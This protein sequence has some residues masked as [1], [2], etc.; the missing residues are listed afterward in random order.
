[1]RLK[2]TA[3]LAFAALAAGAVAAQA[4]PVTVALFRFQAQG[5]VNAFH[6]VLGA[7]CNK[8]WRKRK[9]LGVRVGP[10]TNACGLRS[11]VV[12]DSTEGGADFE[13]AASANLAANTP[14]SLR[15][16]VYLGLAVRSSDTTGYELRVLPLNR[17]WQLWRDAKGPPGPE[18]LASGSGKFIRPGVGRRNDLLLRAFDYGSAT[19]RLL[20]K[21]NGKRVLARADSAPSQPDGRRTVVTV[22]GKGTAVVRGA[23]GSFDNVAIRVP[24]PF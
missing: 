9:S 2:L 4:G 16:K 17:K 3:L 6:K 20:A 18:L 7:K 14:V 1:M 22:G 21:V 24:N 8:K 23:V 15:K 5:D 10:G 13:M 12:G 11:S 19:V